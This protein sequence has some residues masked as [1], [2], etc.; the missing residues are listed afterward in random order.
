[1]LEKIKRLKL[2]I[3]PDQSEGLR[4]ILK[5]TYAT[6]DNAVNATETDEAR[7]AVESLTSQLKASPMKLI[8]LNRMLTREQRSIIMDLIPDDED[9]E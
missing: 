9:D 1:M 2:T 4:V 7:K 6:F 8:R 3:T 5:D